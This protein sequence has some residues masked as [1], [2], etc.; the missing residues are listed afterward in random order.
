MR[1]R[2]L[3]LGF[4]LGAV[5]ALVGTHA[6]SQDGGMMMD[7]DM[8]AMMAAMTPGPEHAAMARR[9]GTYDITAKVYMMGPDG[10]AMESTGTSTIESVLDGRFL[11]ERMSW[12][13]TMPDPQTGQMTEMQIEGMGLAG[14]DN[15]RKQYVSSWADSMNTHMLSMHGSMS[16]DGTTMT[17]YGMMDEPGLGVSNRYVKY[18]MKYIDDDTMLFSIYDLHAG[19][20]YKVVEI[21]YARQK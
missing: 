1:L 21:G 8:E 10:P 18:Q 17:S 4:T 19:E 12:G 13:L 9:A 15:Y 11:F 7:V 6:M 5:T 20:D 3:V 16:E 14:Y 2:T